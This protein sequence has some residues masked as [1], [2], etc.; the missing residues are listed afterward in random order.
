MRERVCVV[1][2]SGM[3]RATE[4]NE[5]EASES[6]MRKRGLRVNGMMSSGESVSTDACEDGVESKLSLRIDTHTL[7]GQFDVPSP[8]TSVMRVPVV[9]WRKL[10]RLLPPRSV[11]FAV[12][13]RMPA[14]VCVPS[15]ALFVSVPVC[16]VS[17]GGF[18][19][20]IVW[21]RARV[22]RVGRVVFVLVLALLALAPETAVR[23]L[24]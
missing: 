2:A 15:C 23:V 7:R 8:R 21:L 13:I 4:A 17:F 16:A 14:V 6:T 24:F 5:R 22:V 19:S 20:F 10:Y 1:S 18:V 12:F 11:L 9:K 3:R